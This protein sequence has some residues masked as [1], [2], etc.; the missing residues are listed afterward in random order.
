MYGFRVHG[1]YEPRIGHRFNHHKVL[2]DPYAKSITRDVRWHDSMFG[3]RIG[4][5]AIDLSFDT[6]D[7]AA[8]A[9]LAAVVDPAFTWGDDRPPRTAWHDTVIYELHVKSFT[10]QHPAVPKRMQGTYAGLA[11]EAALTYLKELG[12]TAVELMPVHYR[13]EIS[14]L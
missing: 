9:P 8:H 14:V 4:D 13:L 12:I 2:L 7:N 3:Y 5:S 6:R 1:P 11:S 10:K